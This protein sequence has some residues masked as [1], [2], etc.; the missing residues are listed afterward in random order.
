VKRLIFLV[1][2]FFSLLTFAQDGGLYNGTTLEK[3]NLEDVIRTIPKGAVV[4][5]GEQHGFG[6]I[7]KGQLDV[8]NAL[9]AN[10]HKVNVGMEF[11]DYTNQEDVD[12]YR[13]GTL[14]ETD[15]L[16]QVGWG[17]V[18]FDFYRDQILF[19]KAEQGE[20]T[21]A[22]NSPRWLSG[23]VSQ[24]GIAGLSEEALK[25]L[26]PQFQ[27]GRESYKKRFIDLMSGH[28]SS[29]E[30]MQR[31]FEAQSLW[32]DTMA[33]N[34]AKMPV[35]LDETI[36]VVVGQFHVEYGGGLPYQLQQRIKNRPVVTIDE[37]LYYDDEKVPFENLKPS[38]EYG[39]MSDYLLI[40]IEKS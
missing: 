28:I 11:L 26:P 14:N 5:L 1:F 3:V 25:L 36:V 17:S 19:P 33:W 40:V 15:F 29:P 16:K 20:R 22:I 38:P 9:R 31:Y 39:P 7:Q 32:D 8:L 27:L 35:A 6:L 34:L 10:G 30:K 21:F 37:L 4:I 12:N 2:S 18:S 23:E 13:N 24:K